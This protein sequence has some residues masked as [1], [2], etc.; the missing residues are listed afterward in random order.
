MRRIPRRVM[1]YLMGVLG[2]VITW[3]LAYWGGMRW[4]ENRPISL[5]DALFFVVETFTTTGY[6][7]HAPW[8]N[9]GMKTIVMLVEIT[10]VAI[11]FL[12]LPILIIPFV[13]ATLRLRPPTSRPGHSGHVIVC[14]L[15][16]RTQLLLKELQDRRG[17]HVLVIQDAA[18]ATDMFRRGVQVVHGD[19]RDASV[20][21]GVG[22]ADA[23]VLI[24]DVHDE[25][26][27]AILLAAKSVTSDV[28][29]LAMADEPNHR[30]LLELAG[31]D[32]VFTPRH[33]VGEQLGRKLVASYTADVVPSIVLADDYEIAEL[34]V[35][36]ACTF[37]GR[38]LDASG[39]RE[40]GGA[41]VI[42][43]WHRG[44]FQLPTG[45]TVVHA[46]SVLTV[47]GTAAQVDATREVL[48]NEG[49]ASRTERI[50]IFGAGEVG[51]SVERVISE[52]GLEHVMVDVDPA[53]EPDIVGD[54][55]DP[56]L[57]ASLDLPSA[58]SVVLTLPSDTQSL[59]AA[60]QIRARSQ[61]V[62]LLARQHEEGQVESLYRAGA[63]Y[64]LAVS[65]VSAR[66]LADVVLPVEVIDLTGQLEIVRMSAGLLTGRSLAEADVRAETGCIIL[67]VERGDETISELPA[68]FR[69]K[70]G[71]TV[72]VLGEDQ[73]V[74]DFELRYNAR[75]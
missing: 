36:P 44:R 58:G 27:A 55:T 69:F 47:A 45:D 3:T 8:S 9:G 56:E 21:E 13:E 71:D 50:I 57:L 64:V 16:A 14:G 5:F 32:Q 19:P 11:I 39:L 20:L 18:V 63:D 61:G 66:Q 51:R 54:A 4:L 59:F 2:L 74:A 46:H 49:R 1:A 62:E 52:A 28:T 43:I 30:P 7:S 53:Q 68:S 38:R 31:A 67:A 29:L 34:P 73:S 15:S 60:L 23:R 33:V 48:R 24:V 25:M 65:V 40:D 42:G 26:N 35:M 70:A 10:G 6:G 41:H 17:D 75:G 72:V 37:S 12:T 22:L